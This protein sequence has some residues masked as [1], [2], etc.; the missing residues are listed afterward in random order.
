MREDGPGIDLHVVAILVLLLPGSIL[1]WYRSGW[2]WPQLALLVS[3]PQARIVV[4]LQDLRR[5]GRTSGVDYVLSTELVVVL[6]AMV[7][8]FAAG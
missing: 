6:A 2:F 4:R 3:I 7:F 1:L 8:A 5:A